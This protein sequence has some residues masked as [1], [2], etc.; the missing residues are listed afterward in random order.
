MSSMSQV[1]KDAIDPMKWV[2]ADDE[3]WA[4]VSYQIMFGF[5]SIVQRS[6]V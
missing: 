2:A 1:K 3:I 4:A 6:S 5:C